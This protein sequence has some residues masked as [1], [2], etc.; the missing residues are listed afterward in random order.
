[1]KLCSASCCQLTFCGVLVSNG[2]KIWVVVPCTVSTLTMQEHRVSSVVLICPMVHIN[3]CPCI[4]KKILCRPCVTIVLV[5]DWCIWLF[6]YFGSVMHYVFATQVIIY[7]FVIPYQD[8][9]LPLTQNFLIGL[10]SLQPDVYFFSGVPGTFKTR[11][12]DSPP[13]WSRYFKYIRHS[14]FF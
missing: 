4:V 6:F 11:W 7:R 9:N 14:G 10:F 12:E 2:Y 8:W 13:D 3:T 1:M 5:R